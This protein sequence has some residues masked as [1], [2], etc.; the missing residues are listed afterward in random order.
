MYLYFY[1]V[2]GFSDCLILQMSLAA[3]GIGSYKYAVLALSF[4]IKALARLCS[5]TFGCHGQQREPW[6][7]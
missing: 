5:G 4:N 7:F 2:C 3:F 1:S 6:G